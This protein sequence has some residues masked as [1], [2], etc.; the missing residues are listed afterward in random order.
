MMNV[1]RKRKRRMAPRMLLMPSR[2]LDA[3]V[4]R[5]PP[6]PFSPSSAA[7]AADFGSS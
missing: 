3:G 6:L 5:F 4:E 7:E 1:L 2:R